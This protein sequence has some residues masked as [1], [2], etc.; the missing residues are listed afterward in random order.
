MPQRWKPEGRRQGP[1]LLR[2]DWLRAQHESA[3]PGHRPGETPLPE[4]YCLTIFAFYSLFGFRLKAG[5]GRR[6]TD[7]TVSVTG[8]DGKIHTVEVK[9]SSL[10][11][12]VDQAAQ[13]W[14]RLWWYGGRCGGRSPGRGSALAGR[15]G[16][17]Q[18]VAG[19]AGKRPAAGFKIAGHKRRCWLSK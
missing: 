8:G 17:G 6:M 3:A 9:A 2:R 1:Q 10:F 16:T 14:A 7:C 4:A 5:A 13:Q 12:A 15:A 19:G 11:D 18:A